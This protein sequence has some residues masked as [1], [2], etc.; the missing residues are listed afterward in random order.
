M[1]RKLGRPYFVME[2]VRG[3]AITEYAMTSIDFRHGNGWSSLSR[4]ARPSSMHIRRGSSTATSSP[5]CAGAR[6][7]DKPVV[8]VIDFGIAK[9]HHQPD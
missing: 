9:A 1:P 2:L 7:D 8:K 3:V 4:F 6:L 5:Q